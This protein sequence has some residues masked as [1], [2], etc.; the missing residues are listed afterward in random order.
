[1]IVGRQIDFDDDGTPVSIRLERFLIETA[2]IYPDLAI[3][4]YPFIIQVAFS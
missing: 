2:L 3:K 1:M 4:V